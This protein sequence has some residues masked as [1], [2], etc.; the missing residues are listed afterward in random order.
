M[1]QQ[2]PLEIQL[3][4]PSLDEIRE[5]LGIDGSVAAG[6]AVPLPEG[7][8]LQVE[9]VSKSSG[10]DV[11]TV[12]LTAVITVATGASKELLM[13]WLKSRLFKSASKPAAVTI[14]IEGKEIQLHPGT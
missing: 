13:E 1:S 7:A 6:F 14:L 8:T 3:I 2:S 9:D 4:G 11:T 12:I 5:V 10:F